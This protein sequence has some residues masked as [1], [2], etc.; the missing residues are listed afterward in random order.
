MTSLRSFGQFFQGL[1]A[2][3][4]EADLGRTPLFREGSAP[5]KEVVRQRRAPC[6][7]VEWQGYPQNAGSSSL[8]AQ[9][10]AS[11]QIQ[12]PSRMTATP[13]GS[14]S[15]SMQKQSR[16]SSLSQGCR[17]QTPSQGWSQM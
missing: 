9:V 1:V 13:F 16:F 15:G 5:R 6:L 8:G 12:Q 17:R 2:T 14:Q 4:P 3:L 10:A 11:T 7:L